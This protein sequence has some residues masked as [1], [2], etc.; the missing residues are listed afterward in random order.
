MKSPSAEVAAADGRS[1]RRQFLEQSA[2]GTVVAA[3]GWA[4][5][6]LTVGATSTASGG[7]SLMVVGDSERGYGVEI[8]FR[9]QPVARHEAGGEFSAVFQNGERSLEDRIENWKA[10]SWSGDST[11]V[12]LRG[13][14]KLSI[15]RQ[16]FLC[17]SN[18]K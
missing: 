4:I 9:G 16:Q 17:K 2:A 18:T 7:V 3:L 5:A 6:P 8:L 10:S 1:S 12:T 15:L 14:Y 11:R 13:E